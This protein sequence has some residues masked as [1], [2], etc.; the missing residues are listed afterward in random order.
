M[1][2]AL[3]VS[4][5]GGLQLY[6]GMAGHPLFLVNHWVSSGFGSVY[7]PSEDGAKEVNSYDVLYGRLQTCR[8]ETGQLPN[9]VAVDFYEHGE[10]FKAVAA[11]NGL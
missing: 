5:R 10:L 6:R 9:F 1:G 3:R 8:A 7:L 4:Q 11:L 2:Y